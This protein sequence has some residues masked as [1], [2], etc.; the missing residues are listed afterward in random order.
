LKA[1]VHRRQ[2]E[3]D[4]RIA[5]RVGDP[6]ARVRTLKAFAVESGRPGVAQY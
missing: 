4:W 5:D 2:I 6:D 3:I 1:R